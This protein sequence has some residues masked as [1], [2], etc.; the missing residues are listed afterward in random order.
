MEVI[1]EEATVLAVTEKGYGKRTKH[2]NYRVQSR[3]GKGV[4]NIQTTKR[5]GPVVGIKMVDTSDGLMIITVRG[6]II[7][8][9][10]REIRSMGRNTQGVRLIRLKPGDK[11]VAVARVM[12]NQE[13]KKEV[14]L[15]KETE[16]VRKR[17]SE[18]EVMEP[19]AIKAEEGGKR[20]RGSPPKKKVSTKGR[21]TSGGK[22]KN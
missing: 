16:K 1:R 11:V 12:A 4:I 21:S 5:N 13:E 15:E 7:Q 20:K 22:S 14:E 3:G 18:K 19:Q 10:I 8:S 17:E 2:T 9:P 6:I